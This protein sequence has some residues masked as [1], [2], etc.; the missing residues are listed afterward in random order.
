MGVHEKLDLDRWLQ[1]FPLESMIEEQRAWCAKFGHRFEEDWLPPNRT[2]S[3]PMHLAAIEHSRRTLIER[4][5]DLGTPI[6]TDVFLWRITPISDG[7]VTR[8]GGVPFRDPHKLWPTSANGERLPFLA[9]ISFLDSMDL[10]PDDLPGEILC[11]YGNWVDEH[12]LETE[13]LV[14]EWSSRDCGRDADYQPV[15]R[16]K[17]CAEGVIHRAFNY[18]DLEHLRDDLAIDT[19]D[20]FQSTQIGGRPSYPQGD[21]EDGRRA[22]AT[23]SS[24]QAAER[25]PFIN[26]HEIPRF[27][28]PKGHEGRLDDLFSM[29]IGD[30]GSIF[31]HRTS[32]G[33]YEHD[34]NC[35]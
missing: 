33:T 3:S 24:F 27:T 8:I 14:L 34:W 30:M 6:P 28:Y 20:C 2:I 35:Y 21:P 10:V 11:V 32:S 16:W 26:C 25:W 4:G 13:S 17:F 9:Q 31:I 19:P 22:V 15:P 29:V 7:P 23:F 12:A 5:F 1:E 18:P